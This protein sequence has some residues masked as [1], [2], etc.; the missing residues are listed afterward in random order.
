MKSKKEIIEQFKNHYQITKSGLSKQYKHIQECQAFYAGDYM[1]YQDNYAFG[2]GSSVRIKEVS[3][4]RVKPYVNS[5]VGFMAQ[6]R[7]KPDYQAKVPDNKEQQAL[8]EYLNGLSDYVRENNNADQ[9]ETK[10]DMDLIIGGVGATD[11]ALTERMGYATR[12]PNGEILV[13]RV[14]PL[15][16]G[17]DPLSSAPNL[18][19]TRWVYRAK[20]YDVEEALELFNAD[21]EDFEFANNQDNVSNLDYNPFGGIQ[22]KI[23]YEWADPKRKIVRVYFYQYFEIENFYRVENPLLTISNPNL[24]ALLITAL[25][26]VESDVEDEL[27]RF[28]PSADMLVI[29]KDNR[30]QI[31]DLFEL[32][33][34]PFKPMTGK[35]KV[36]YT[37][38]LSGDKIF[39]HYKSPS[40]QGF[41]LK[42]K[43]GDRDEVNKIHT[44]IV[45]SMRDPQRY[46]NKSLTELMLI[47][48]NNSR[49]GVMVEESAVDNI[50]E[51]EAKWAKFNS[52]VMVNDGALS[53]GAIKPKAIPAMPT[54]YENIMAASGDA[55][56]QVTG[57]DESFFGAIAGGN[58]TAMLQRQRI[59]QATTVL[60]CFFDSVS[61]YAKEQARLMM[62][63]MRTLAAASEGAL[64]KVSDSDGNVVFEQLSSD[65][66]ADE[67]E[68]SIGE[69]PETPVQKEY[70]TQT[71]IGMAQSMQAIG[72]PRYLQ[73]YAA[74]VK[75]M[76]IANRDKNQVTQ[77]LTG[78]K[79]YSEEQ[80]QQTIQPL[81]QQIQMLQSEQARVEVAN[82][83]VDIAKKQ[84]EIDKIRNEIEEMRVD[85]IKTQAETE[86]TL[87]EAEGRSLENDIMVREK[88]KDVN[89][90]V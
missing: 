69:A 28:D 74:A 18:T 78:A 58:E 85:N 24:A 57:I 16:V 15:T 4:N 54:G 75:Y 10:Q 79:Q 22:D 41:S 56:G 36:F 55:L 6:Q 80:I 17:Y 88:Y 1:Q 50:R 14:D 71:L 11:T 81:Q 60:A 30:A 34:L 25:R 23:G 59:K 48:A 31:K 3:F 19:D 45:A 38:I 29:T 47:I 64:F 51:F 76:P 8:S 9:V 61:L 7:R 2:R 5:I 27:F 68:V 39:D 90:T 33:D 53:N 73:M 72:D 37:V 62:T 35:R 87:E 86:K 65:F 44:G 49:G 46:Y 42:F 21:E 32:Y 77:L 89:L 13:E 84:A 83:S 26:N 63:F 20:E 66:F 52:V 40:Q 70:Y 67:Y 82:K 43:V 12:D